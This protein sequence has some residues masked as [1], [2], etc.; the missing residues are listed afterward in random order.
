MELGV[1]SIHRQVI[2][3]VMFS[4]VMAACAARATPIP[5]LMATEPLQASATAPIIADTFTPSSSLGLT[6]T[7]RPSNG[8]QIRVER[9]EFNTGTGFFVVGGRLYDANG[10][11]FRIRGVNKV[12]YEVAWPG[13]PKTHA[14]TIRWVA[15]LW[16]APDAIAQLVQSII[17]AQIAPMPGVW[18][19]S[20]TWREA[21]NVVCNEDVAYL[22][23]AVNLWVAQ[24]A[25]LKP[26]ERH[27][28]INIASEWGPGDSTI[29]RDAYIQAVADLR[30]AGYLG[31]LVIDTGGCGQDPLNI[32]RYGQQV[33]N[34]D[35]QRNIVFD[36]HVYG[37]WSN[38]RGESWQ[39]DLNAGFDSLART[40]LPILIGEFG[41]GRNIGPS[42]TL[43]TPGEIITASEARGFG[44]LAW[45]WDDPASDVPDNWFALSFTGNYN[46]SAD[47]TTFGKEVVENPAYG[48]LHLAHPAAP[49]PIR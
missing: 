36:V 31:T 29:W 22:R 39:T 5:I 10:V 37:L 14:N 45:A 2:I 47:L 4:L 17:S 9:P 34:S 1:M 32:V 35:P 21:D 7:L 12:H 33:F 18:Y 20:D 19:T 6:S 3:Y 43:I 28:L 30:A 38:G 46:S 23:R 8:S 41:P 44:W 24:A 16:L 42:P 26:F 48:L 25:T 49:W 11:E 13:I 27:L 40:G 15:P